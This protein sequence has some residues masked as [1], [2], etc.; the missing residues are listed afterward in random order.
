MRVAH[1]RVIPNAHLLKQYTEDG[2][3]EAFNFGT[4]KF[5]SLEE[6][7]SPFLPSLEVKSSS[8]LSAT[9][10]TMCAQIVVHRFIVR[11]ASSQ[12]SSG[13]SRRG[14][15]TRQRSAYTSIWKCHL[16]IT[17]GSRV[18]GRQGGGII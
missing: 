11:L 8:A 18:K 9:A 16:E 17:S 6:S 14:R 3:P 1:A 10:T 4:M 5:V 7:A 15:C 2:S 12:K 13:S